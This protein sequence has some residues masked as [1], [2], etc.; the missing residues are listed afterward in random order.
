MV[1]ILLVVTVIYLLPIFMHI[2]FWGEMDWDQFTFW[3]AVPR[4]TILSYRQI[5]LWNP[6]SNGGTVLLAHPF[7]AFLSPF[8]I[9]VLFFG[10][11]AGLKVQI[12]V[13]LFITMLG[14]SM[15]GRNQGMTA[16]A[17]LLCAFVFGL[18]SIHAL[19]IAEG[20]TEWLAVAFMPW[21]FLLFLKTLKGG[22]PWG[23]GAAMAL[24]FMIFSGSVNI[25]LVSVFLLFLVSLFESLRL[26]RALPFLVAGLIC[27][28]AFLISGVKAFP[29][30]EFVSANP[31]KCHADGRPREI[32]SEGNIPLKL[33][34]T[35]LLSPSQGSY[36]AQT[37]GDGVNKIVRG[38]PVNEAWHEY[39][40][41]IGVIPLILA[42]GGCALTFRTRWPFG[43]A[44]LILLLISVGADWR[45]CGFW[46]MLRLFPFYSTCNNPSRFIVGFIM[47]AALFA[48]W[49][50]D[51][52][53]RIGKHMFP[54][55]AAG[56]VLFVLFDL[57]NV[58]LPILAHTFT[59]SPPAIQRS[60]KF[61]Q[62]YLDLNLF[63]GRSRSS[64]FAAFL[65]NSGIINSYEVLFVPRG[66]VRALHDPEYRG[67]VFV[68]DAENS[69]D[70]LYFSPNKLIVEAVLH[71]DDILVVNQNY[72]NGWRVRL[73]GR[74]YLPRAY[75]G[76]LSVQLPSAGKY[77]VVFYYL[78][79]SFLVGALITLIS[80]M[81]GLVLLTRKNVSHKAAVIK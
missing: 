20:H 65:E 21:L 28:A 36:Y 47:C 40:A 80:L 53:G 48:G 55:W 33:L 5:P 60:S 59:L 66:D 45:G 13:S 3:N 7:S 30:L 29:L 76:L 78:P 54:Y 52:V 71:G 43:L 34:G 24:V 2:P 25:V 39:G 51:A 41:Y 16:Q 62:R 68:L 57:A 11:V 17:S 10:A 56:I 31:V 69:A 81:G 27:L 73:N 50:L 1:L 32:T 12:A 79:R 4:L 22:M 58:N 44:G 46:N 75:H 23:A 74:D 15:L 64:M 72:D 19:H 9:F 38:V 8:Y 70:I 26:K 37:K 42:L 35:S 77:R 6:Y 49:G 63:P 61:A 18:S 67:E 14:I